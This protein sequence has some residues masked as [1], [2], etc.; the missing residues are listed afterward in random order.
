M[1]K[2]RVGDKVLYKEY[3][4]FLFKAKENEGYIVLRLQ[5]RSVV[6]MNDRMQEKV[7]SVRVLDLAKDVLAKKKGES[8]KEEP[9]PAPVG[10]TKE[11]FFDLVKNKKITFDGWG[12]TSYFIP[13][14][15]VGVYMAGDQYEDGQHS[16]DKKWT[17]N[18][19]LNKDNAWWWVTKDYSEAD[20]GDT[21]YV[22]GRKH[23]S[24]SLIVCSLAT[25]RGIENPSV[26]SLLGKYEGDGSAIVQSLDPEDFIV[27]ADVDT[28]PKVDVLV[29][30]NDDSNP[31]LSLG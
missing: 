18:F 19:Q 23:H 31:W 2:F 17:G 12:P 29:V 14:A 24:H 27:L 15:L 3:Q 22:I 21:V 26:Y 6:L 1:A 25:I 11:A 4:P 30:E 16:K 9:I 20:V 8:K 13:R 28:V 5:G 10:L 7:V